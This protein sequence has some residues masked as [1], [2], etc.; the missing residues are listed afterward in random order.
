MPEIIKLLRQ[1]RIEKRISQKELALSIGFG[2][3]Q[4][5]N[6]ERGIYGPTL[7]NAIRWAEALG[8]EFDMHIKEPAN[9]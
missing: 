5:A 7:A 6:W 9:V 2:E 3:N 8:Y 1:I 4:V